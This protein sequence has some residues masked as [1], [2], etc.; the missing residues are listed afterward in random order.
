M[1]K[2]DK[3]DSMLGESI[4]IRGVTHICIAQSADALL[5]LQMD[6]IGEPCQYVVAHSPYYHECGLCWLSG[7]YYPL[8]NHPDSIALLANVMNEMARRV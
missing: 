4:F 8:W 7:D 2:L 5:F 3:D 6:E 1:C